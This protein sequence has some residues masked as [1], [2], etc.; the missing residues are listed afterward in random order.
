M[1]KFPSHD[2]FPQKVGA[3]HVLYPT[4][5]SE[6]ADRDRIVT[7]RS[8]FSQGSGGIFLAAVPNVF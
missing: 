6:W 2:A 1:T 7:S 5:K 3:R 8:A 4:W